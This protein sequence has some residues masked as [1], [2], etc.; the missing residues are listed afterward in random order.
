MKTGRFCPVG[1][2]RA[3]GMGRSRA[4][5][6]ASAAGLV[7]ALTHAPLHAQSTPDEE[8]LRQRQRSE[9]LERQQRL[10]APSVHLPAEGEM[11]GAEEF[12]AETPCF[13][14]QG[15][16]LEGERIGD[17][18]W[19]QAELARP[20]GRCLGR[21]GINLVVRRIT[22][23]FLA[24]GYIT[25]RIGL[26]EQDLS[27]GILRLTLIPGVIGAIRFA[28]E[29]ADASWR[30]AF[31][32]RPGDLLNLRDLEQ[33]LEQLKRVPSQ[34]AEIRI[35]PGSRPGES[36]VV[37]DLK[38]GKPWR[39]LASL[40]DSGAKATGRLQAGLTIALDNPLGLN[41]LFSASLNSDAERDGMMRG[42]RGSSFSWSAPWGYWTASL[43]GSAY[44]YRQTVQ[45]TSQRFVS[46]GE[47]Q[48]AEFRLH[49]VLH[50][51][52]TSKTGVQARLAKR[53]ARSFIEDTE[54]EV[55]R[56][57][58]TSAEFALTHRHYFGPAQLDAVLA[59]R[60]GVPW[61][62]GQED[63]PGRAS[64]SPTFR[65]RLQTLDVG[66]S[67]PFRLGET[68]LRYL[69]S[70]R[71]QAGSSPLYASEFFAIGSR[72]TVR[73][74]DG[75]QL[76]AA[77]RGWF[78]RNELEFP[79]GASGQSLYA[80]LDHGELEGPSVATLP[81]DRLT[82][83]A[84]G[85]RGAVGGAFYDLFA[86]WPLYKPAGYRTAQPAAGFQLIYQY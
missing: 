17:F 38:R 15:V 46:S 50:R 52:Q 5:A 35:L 31:P 34:D 19:M 84:V 37:I 53:W 41:D 4:G 47:V 40:D 13:R 81:G 86:G 12:P 10:Q 60:E 29:S 59:H 2:G 69:G 44:R 67:V 65:Y 11:V 71:G 36:E 45:G 42:T 80:G 73:G 6:W 8:T 39:L 28:D 61:W 1:L 57:N 77:E 56:R 24:R 27:S 51:D 20:I 82:G 32:A 55:Q 3:T 23:E 70:F 74:F 14:I 26:P 66:L 83:A 18:P 58:V 33:G 48:N 30:S 63:A 85:L 7:F 49:R 43:G 78:L 68:P 76:L 21:E 75:E 9:T 25:T 72:Y 22:N 62:N 64:A 16:Q 54:I 79:L